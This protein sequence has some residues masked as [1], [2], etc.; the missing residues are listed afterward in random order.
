MI[1]FQAANSI[2]YLNII[3][4]VTY[5]KI[6]YIYIIYSGLIFTHIR[7]RYFHK[8][9]VFSEAVRGFHNRQKKKRKNISLIPI[10]LS[11]LLNNLLC[12]LKII[13]KKQNMEKKN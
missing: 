6:I 2:L 7:S 5:Q 11:S 12:L 10:K 3:E 8:Q 1:E 13:K 4:K 9:Q